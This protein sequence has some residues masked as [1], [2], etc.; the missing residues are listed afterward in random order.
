MP[1]LKNENFIPPFKTVRF[2]ITA[3]ITNLP[4]FQDSITISSYPFKVIAAVQFL[5][6]D[7]R[8]RYSVFT[9]QTQD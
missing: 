2:G 3:T 8:Y 9:T 7:Y 4:G 5:V 1:S 6:Y